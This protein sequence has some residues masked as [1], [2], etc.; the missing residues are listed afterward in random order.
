LTVVFSCEQIQAKYPNATIHRSKIPP[1]ESARAGEDIIW[2]T[3]V[4][5]E[6]DPAHPALHHGV[7]AN[8]Q[9]YHRFNGVSRFSST[10]PYMVDPEEREAV[11]TWTEKTLITS[12]SDGVIFAS[13]RM[14]G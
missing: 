12:Q 8:V 5:A 9:A 1:S 10:R 7:P 4:V 11:L 6:P 2:I 14:M 3:S 13:R